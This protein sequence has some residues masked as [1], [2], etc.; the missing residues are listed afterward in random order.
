[1]Q[2]QAKK[3]IYKENGNFYLKNSYS[4]SA[5]FALGLVNLGMGLHLPGK[6][7][8]DLDERLIKLVEGGALQ[9]AAGRKAA[10]F[11]REAKNSSVKL[12]FYFLDKRKQLC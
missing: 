6:Q 3:K 1:M 11:K 12:F 7:E 5:G 9:S 4:L 10:S 2:D 8:I